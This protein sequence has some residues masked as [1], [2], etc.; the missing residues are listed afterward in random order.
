MLFDIVKEFFENYVVFEGYGDE[1][2]EQREIFMGEFSCGCTLESVAEPDEEIVWKIDGEV[3]K[4]NDLKYN[5]LEYQ[6]FNINEEI[7]HLLA[8]RKKIAD[9]MAEIE[10]AEFVENNA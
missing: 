4:P 9:E 5:F 8:A 7:N 1:E 10:V 2:E 6:L 3:V